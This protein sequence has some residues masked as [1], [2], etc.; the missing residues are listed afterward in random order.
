[1]GIFSVCMCFPPPWLPYKDANIRGIAGVTVWWVKQG[2]VPLFL[3]VFLSCSGG[4][5]RAS[6]QCACLSTGSS[7]HVVTR[8]MECGVRRAELPNAQCAPAL[9]TSC[10]Y[11]ILNVDLTYSPRL[12]SKYGGIA[13]RRDH[14]Y[15]F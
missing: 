10:T 15:L 7:K 2:C 5:R 6:C 12:P 13:R 3:I 9:P 8:V 14:V 11:P 1:M 4:G